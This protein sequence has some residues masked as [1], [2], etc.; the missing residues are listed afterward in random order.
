V[1]NLTNSPV[2]Q[3]QDATTSSSRTASVPNVASRA[4]LKLKLCLSAKRQKTIGWS[5]E[6]DGHMLNPNKFILLRA[7]AAKSVLH[8]A[9]LLKVRVAKDHSVEG[10]R[11]WGLDRRSW[12]LAR[13]NHVPHP[14]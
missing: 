1:Q 9:Q 5:Y 14:C 10:E 3:V 2:V 11:Y 6:L 13:T 4:S 8:V 12:S 7:F